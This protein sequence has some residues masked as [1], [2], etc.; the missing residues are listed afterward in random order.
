MYWFLLASYGH[1]GGNTAPGQSFSLNGAD[2]HYPR[3]IQ[4]LS[5]LRS[6]MWSPMRLGRCS[7]LKASTLLRPFVSPILRLV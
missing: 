3:A 5:T 4:L 7:H 6:P 1:P 2:R